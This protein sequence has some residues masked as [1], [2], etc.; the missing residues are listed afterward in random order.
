[1]I[2]CGVGFPRGGCSRRDWFPRG[3]LR[4][5]V[6]SSLSTM[7]SLVWL[8]IALI[9]LWILVRM[10]FAVTG[11]FLHLLW[12]AALIFAAIWLFNKFAR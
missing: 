6:S 8:A 12:I 11:F 2:G 9:V 7:N 3:T 10:V 1:M 4:R 5:L